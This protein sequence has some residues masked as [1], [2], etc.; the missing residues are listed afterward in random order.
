MASMPTEIKSCALTG[1][2]GYVGGRIKVA[3]QQ[4]GWRVLD[5]TRQAVAGNPSVSFRLGDKVDPEL[6]AG[7]D[8]LVH[9]AY[10]FSARR[11]EDIERVNVAG[12]EKLFYA[13]RKAGVNHVVFISSL[14]AFDS[15][16]SLYGRA[17]LEIEALARKFDAVIIR[18]GLVYGDK[19]G[20]VFGGLV[21]QARRSRVIPLLGSGKQK[22]FLLHDEDLCR[23]VARCAGGEI[24]A[25][26]GL[27]SLAHEEGWTV[28]SIL[29]ELARARA[30][31]PTFVP[32][33]WRLAW[34]GLK[35][36]ELLALPAPFRSDSLIGLIYQ[37]PAPSFEAAKKLGARCRPFSVTPAM[38]A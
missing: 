38:V 10:D 18:P 30:G 16:R 9:C 33:P 29:E 20:G 6:F 13:A 25:D 12:T 24:S 21:R 15:C 28:R 8:A 14:S 36:L 1:A 11:W 35:T 31:R 17:K 23:F 19:P 4:W 32:V 27:I 26:A 3:L 22:Q 37:N 5:W 34:L 2:T 7:T